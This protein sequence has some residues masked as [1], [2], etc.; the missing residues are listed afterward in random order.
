[1]VLAGMHAC[2]SIC[3]LEAL[4]LSPDSTRKGELCDTQPLPSVHRAACTIHQVL[5]QSWW[6]RALQEEQSIEAD[7]LATASAWQ[8]WVTR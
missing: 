2:A 5:F 1:M 8:H 6:H 4:E 7:I 3:Q